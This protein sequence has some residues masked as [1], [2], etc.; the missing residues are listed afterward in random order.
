VSKSEA[1]KSTLLLNGSETLAETA[2]FLGEL[3]EGK[4][5]I[6]GPLDPISLGM[7]DSLSTTTCQ[8]P[9]EETFSFDESIPRLFRKMAS[10][11]TAFSKMRIL[12]KAAA[13]RSTGALSL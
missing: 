9:E 12:S 8:L 3:L 2:I 6:W 13:V 4:G 1:S 10:E 11:A 5:F 7:S